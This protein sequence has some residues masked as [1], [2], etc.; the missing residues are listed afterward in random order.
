MKTQ[1]T[2]LQILEH[3]ANFG[4]IFG[5]R[6]THKNEYIFPTMM[7]EA[8]SR[9]VRN[10][11]ITIVP[12]MVTFN[13]ANVIFL[14]RMINVCIFGGASFISTFCLLYN[15]YK[16]KWVQY[17]LALC[18]IILVYYFGI[19][20]HQ[21]HVN[22]FY[23]VIFFASV[24]IFNSKSDRYKLLSLISIMAFLFAL[25]T[26]TNFNDSKT[27]FLTDDQYHTLFTTNLIFF[28]TL[29]VLTMIYVTEIVKRAQ[30]Y[31]NVYAIDGTTQPQ[32]DIV[33]LEEVN[34]LKQE[35]YEDYRGFMNHFQV[36]FP[37]FYE[38]LRSL[39]ILSFSE[40]ELLAFIKLN[41]TTGEIAI[42][43]N[44]SLKSVECKKYRLRKKLEIPREK[45]LY[46]WVQDF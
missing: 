15:L 16:Y 25:N 38:N 5:T 28:V 45:S 46:T 6:K 39:E 27:P 41:F 13:V 36:L 1:V 24:L 17:I 30:R 10:Y 42:I 43:T 22:I 40:I 20:R 26:F 37:I 7:G 8:N 21:S 3:T 23:V 31:S 34:R 44:S 29:L 33:S 18:S 2:E 11:L 4:T 12:M 32:R 9:L 35:L 14:Q 19:D